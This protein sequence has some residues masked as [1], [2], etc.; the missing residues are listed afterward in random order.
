M[1]CRYPLIAKIR[2]IPISQLMF[3]SPRFTTKHPI[4]ASLTPYSAVYSS[5][6]QSFAV[7]LLAALPL[8]MT[9]SLAHNFLEEGQTSI[10][11]AF[12]DDQFDLCDLMIQKDFTLDFQPD[13]PFEIDFSMKTLQCEFVPQEYGQQ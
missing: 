11:K 3:H 4:L 6:T 13:K 10:P 1:F 5:L 9:Q 2:L 8:V 12:F 7:M